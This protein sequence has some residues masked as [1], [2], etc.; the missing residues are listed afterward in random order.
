MTPYYDENGITIYHGKAELV[1]PQLEPVDVLVT[2]P[3]YGIG[4][5]VGQANRGNKRHGKAMV[6]SRD[7]G[8]V[9]WDDKPPAR[10]LLEQMIEKAKWSIIFGGNHFGL[11]AS[12]CWL[13]WDK[14]NGTNDYAD[15]ELV[16]TNLKKAVRR[17]KF[18]ATNRPS[19]KTTTCGGA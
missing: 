3:P 4:A 9:G 5:D 11:P 6:V 19:S 13:V 15:C 10:W 8:D 12:S 17:T 1:V 14:D 18:R 16:W 7:Y 2:D